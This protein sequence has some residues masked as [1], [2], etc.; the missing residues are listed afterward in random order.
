LGAGS[1]LREDL[2]IYP[3]SP[4]SSGFMTA[5]NCRK[6]VEF[7]DFDFFQVFNSFCCSDPSTI[8][9]GGSASKSTPAGVY[10]FLG[11]PAAPVSDVI[12]FTY[13]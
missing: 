1:D 3:Y 9:F 4:L 7:G 8:T 6:Y 11:A 12:A 13:D 2:L 5:A 10:S